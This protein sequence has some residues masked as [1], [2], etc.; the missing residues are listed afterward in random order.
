MVGFA[1]V[2]AQSPSDPAPAQIFMHF[3][4]LTSQLRTCTPL[5]LLH[6]R[7]ERE[8]RQ[9]Y[10]RF[11]IDIEIH[12]RLTVSVDTCP[13]WRFRLDYDWSHPPGM[14]PSAQLLRQ[15]FPIGPVLPLDPQIF[16]L[17]RRIKRILDRGLQPLFPHAEVR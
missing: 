16:N 1:I 2:G 3:P 14:D 5:P 11:Q 8:R 6:S 4:K 12:S 9:L 15:L 10:R 17:R 7:T 13:N